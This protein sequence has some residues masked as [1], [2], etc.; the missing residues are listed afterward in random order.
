MLDDRV[1]VLLQGIAIGIGLCCTLGPQSLFVLRQGM[2][3]EAALRVATICSLG[4]LLMAAAGAAGFGVFLATFPSLVATASW[5]SAIFVLLYGGKLLLETLQRQ[6]GDAGVVRPGRRACVTMT[7][8]ALA[9]LNPQVYLEMVGIVGSLAL[10]VP[11]AE[12]AFFALGVMLVS[13]L[14]FYGLAIGGQRLTSLFGRWYALRAVDLL[15]AAVLL[16]IGAVMVI[17]EAT[18]AVEP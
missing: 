10:R 2:R 12:R 6:P 9:L 5:A 15:T 16:A 3:G 1:S 11:A 17:A 14:W 13:P 18:Q 7:A 8:L 4:D